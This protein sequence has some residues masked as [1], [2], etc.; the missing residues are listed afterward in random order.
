[1]QA[2]ASTVS[3]DPGQRRAIILAGGEGA[4]LQPFIKESLGSDKPKQFCSFWD[5]ESLLEHT[6]RRVSTVVPPENIS[7]VIGKGQ[8]KYLKDLDLSEFS[9]RVLEQGVSRGTG[10]AVFLAL[11]RLASLSPAAPVLIVPSDHFVVPED[12]FIRHLEFLFSIAESHPHRILLLGARADRAETEFGYIQ[13]GQPLQVAS[14]PGSGVRDVVE[15]REKPSAPEAER[16]V[17][18]GALWSTMVTLATPGTLWSV[19]KRALP[20]TMGAFALLSRR[21]SR[22]PPL[23]SAQREMERQILQSVPPFDFSSDLISHSVERS[24]VLPLE[25]VYWTDLG[26][27]EWLTEALELQ[28]DFEGSSRSPLFA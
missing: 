22:Q 11:A 26:R 25:D 13:P 16:L 17:E 24:A 20:E 10:G 15:F 28:R 1:M 23:R 18:D 14:D 2:S 27:E 21:L 9:G 4:R 7:I 3:A 19:G 6:V 8:A 12:R 5:S